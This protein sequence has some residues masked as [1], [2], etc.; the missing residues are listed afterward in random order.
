MDPVNDI[1]S[2]MKDLFPGLLSFVLIF[3]LTY[4]FVIL[5]FAKLQKEKINKILQDKLHRPNE[6]IVFDLLS[7]NRNIPNEFIRNDFLT[8]VIYI[9]FF[10]G[11]AF[12]FYKDLKNLLE[13][14]NISK[15]NI[16]LYYFI[17]FTFI[18]MYLWHIRAKFYRKLHQMIRKHERE[19]IIL[20][21]D[22]FY[23]SPFIVLYDPDQAN[24]KFTERRPTFIPWENFKFLKIPHPLFNRRERNTYIYRFVKNNLN[25]IVVNR[26]VFLAQ[27]KEFINLFSKYGKVFL[28]D[29]I[30]NSTEAM[31]FSSK[32]VIIT[33]VILIAVFVLLG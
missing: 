19:D 3:L 16:F 20:T 18:S 22:G 32:T 14:T 26:S 29:K 2:F 24:L 25:E 4:K 10:I 17:I 33:V 15:S 27:E 21:K 1:L 30:R 6:K 5:R 11:G 13:G 8:L 23:L 9:V 7:N 28:E 12:F 31:S